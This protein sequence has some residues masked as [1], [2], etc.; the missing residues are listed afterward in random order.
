MYAIIELQG[1]STT[2][3]GFLPKEVFFWS[4]EC[5]KRYIINPPQSLNKFSAKDKK[6]IVW[7]THMY[8][9]IPWGIGDISLKD[10]IEDIKAL[11]CKYR[12]ILTKGGEKAAYLS[13][14]LN[15]RV[16]DLTFYGCPSIRNCDTKIKSCNA[17]YPYTKNCAISSAAIIREFL[18]GQRNIEALFG[19]AEQKDKGKSLGRSVSCGSSTSKVK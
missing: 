13:K 3:F 17:H 6:V 1:F 19:R 10:F 2:G 9:N 15:R 5:S 7:N 11:T 14:L 4:K 12:F 8:H 18:N 16:F